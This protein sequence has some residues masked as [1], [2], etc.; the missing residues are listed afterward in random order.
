MKQQGAEPM[1]EPGISKQTVQRLPFYLGY[2]KSLQNGGP[3]TISATTIAEALQLNQVQVRKDLAAISNSGRPKVGYVTRDLS[4]EIEHFLGYDNADNAVIVGAGKLGKALLSY[5][6]FKTYG[7]NIVAAFDNN[8]ELENT[9][10]SGKFILPMSKLTDLCERMK[11]HIGIITVPGSYA[12][13]VCDLL[14]KSGVLAIWNF[15]PVH[16]IVPEGILV[17]NE[18]MASSL[19]VLSNHLNQKFSANR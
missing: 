1:N 6:G 16:L 14:V 7:L 5:D 17:Q 3:E 15:A 18:N 2:L 4:R 8:P 19:A 13:Q 11:I 10:E 9:T 12:Q